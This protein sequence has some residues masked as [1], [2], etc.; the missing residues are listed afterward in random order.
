MDELRQQNVSIFL[1]QAY[2][3]MD[4]M[5]ASSLCS[6]QQ[7]SKDLEQVCTMHAN[8]C[9]GLQ[10][11]LKDLRLVKEDW[12]CFRQ[13]SPQMKKLQRV[14]WRAPRQCLLSFEV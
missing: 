6:I 2:S 11:K 7:V 3:K 9:T 8:C 10:R 1:S 4:L 14:Y 13:M 12:K 5:V